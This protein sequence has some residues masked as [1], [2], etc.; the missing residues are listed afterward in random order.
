MNIVEVHN[1]KTAKEFL[2]FPVGLYKDEEKWIRPLDKEINGIFDPKVNKNFRKGKCIRWILQDEHAKTIGRVAA[3]FDRSLINKDNDQPTGG[4]GFFECINDQEAANKLFD[5]A[6]KW[7]M[8]H[9]IEAMDGPINFGSRDAWWGLLVKGFE[10]EPN[11]QCDYHFPYYQN[12]FE[13]YGFQLYFKQFTYGRDTVSPLSEKLERKAN[14]IKKDPDYTFEHIKKKNLKKYVDDF[15]KVYNES[16]GKV[17]G[18][19]KMS[20][21]QAKV[22]MKKMKP[23]MDEKIIWFAY[24]KGECV[25]FYINIPEINQIFKHLNGKMNLLGKLKF[26]Y[27]QYRKTCKKMVGLVFGITPAHQGKG[28]DGA[29]IMK[30][31]EMVQEKYKRYD[32]YEMTWIGDFN[33]LM[34]RVAEQGGGKIIKTHHTYR[35]LFDRKKPFKRL[36]IIS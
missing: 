2:L 24:Y 22:L 18:V 26:S 17:R 35:Y 4:I 12:L 33:P 5:T 25:A 15:R 6:K 31:R 1:K 13:N 32:E 29:I 23:I 9:D 36:K 28:L 7:L 34:Q 30:T 19:S 20:D 21:L 14:L 27:H 3:F 10:L 11:Y 16:W 8:T